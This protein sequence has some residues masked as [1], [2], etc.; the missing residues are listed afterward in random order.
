MQ[1]AQIYT[2]NIAQCSYVIGSGK[3]CVAVDPVRD[4]GPYL[5][6]AKAFKMEIVAVLETHL[7]ADFVSGHMYKFSTL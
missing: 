2:P 6:K 3:K 7:H 1:I 4:I 5:E